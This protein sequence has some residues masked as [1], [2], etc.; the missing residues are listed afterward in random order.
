[1]IHPLSAEEEIR[2]YLDVSGSQAI[3]TL[4]R[5]YGKV[6]AAAAR[7]KRK[8]KLW[9][10]RLRPELKPLMRLGYDLTQGRKTPKAPTGGLHALDGPAAQSRRY[11]SAGRR[12]VRCLRQHPL[13]RRHDRH[14]EGHLPF[15]LQLQRPCAADHRSQRL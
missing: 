4:D 5:F 2:F 6:A 9:I 11:A 7:A 15:Q 1:M 3:L 13:F 14:D 8:P 12:P 10:A